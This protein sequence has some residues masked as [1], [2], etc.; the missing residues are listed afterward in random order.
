MLNA[1]I[2]EQIVQ[3]KVYRF[4][5]S[6]AEFVKSASL[7]AHFTTEDFPEVAFVGRS[8]VGK[9]TLL[10][11][12]AERKGLAIT[13]KTPGR[14]RL[15]N[16]FQLLF[17]DR[18]FDP[19]VQ[20]EARFVDLPGF[21]YA[22]VGKSMKRDWEKVLG[23]YLFGRTQLRGILL[24][25]DA[26]REI[27]EE[28]RLVTQMAGELEILV[29]LT[30]AD[31]LNRNEQKQAQQKFARDL[32]VAKDQVIITST[33]SPRQGIEELREKIATILFQENDISDLD[34]LEAE[35]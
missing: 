3:E 5:V 13:S 28:E 25:V 34:A 26:R 8:N 27:Q 18:S 24:L 7:P 22:E 20:V 15:V 23:N 31:K 33:N 30:K 4:T 21:G 6:K 9:S 14:T 1:K 32:G 11:S 12:L 17:K 10:N 29:V 16:F 19:P 2:A 35:G